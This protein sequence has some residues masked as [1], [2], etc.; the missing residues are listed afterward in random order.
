MVSGRDLGCPAN[1]PAR[2]GPDTDQ[3]WKDCRARELLPMLIYHSGLLQQRF[4]GMGAGHLPTKGG[5]RGGRSPSII[6]RMRS[7]RA[8]TRGIGA[9]P[10]FTSSRRSGAIFVVG[11]A[12]TNLWPEIA[13]RNAL[14]MLNAA[15]KR[16]PDPPPC[17]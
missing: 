10:A 15:V 16:A 14:G 9:A 6:V 2:R 1:L 17:L 3:R 7:L 8:R 13:R 5:A 4:E 11:P 12:E